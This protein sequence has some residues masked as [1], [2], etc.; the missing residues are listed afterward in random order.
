MNSVC[1]HAYIQRFGDSLQAM[2]TPQSL[3]PFDGV[4]HHVHNMRCSLGWNV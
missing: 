1:V 4:Y 3:P 2:E